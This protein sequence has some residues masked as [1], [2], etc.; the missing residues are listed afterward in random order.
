M[1][2][3]EPRNSSSYYCQPKYIYSL[4]NKTQLIKDIQEYLTHVFEGSELEPGS[5]LEISGKGIFVEV[6]TPQ[7]QKRSEKGNKTTVNLEKCESLLRKETNIYNINDTFYILKMDI[8]EEGMKIPIIEYELYYPLNGTLQ[9]IN[10]SK[11]ESLSVDI[12]IPVTL[13]KDLF[14]HNM[15]SEYYNNDCITAISESDTDICL[16]DRKKEFIEQ[17]LTLCQENCALIDYDFDTKK[18]KCKCDIKV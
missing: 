12:S 14:M 7:N 18:S 11:C 9:K 13:D 2:L 6:T 5:D 8:E 15:S 3:T 16:N 17:N 1:G 10:L 4:D